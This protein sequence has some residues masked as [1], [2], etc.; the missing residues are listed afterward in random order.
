M[1]KYR[2]MGLLPLLLF[3]TMQSQNLHLSH[4]SDGFSS[5]VELSRH[6]PTNANLARNSPK[7]A[8]TS[9]PE[10]LEI[11]QNHSSETH[12]VHSRS[13][14]HSAPRTSLF[15][16]EV[17][18]RGSSTEIQTNSQNEQSSK[19]GSGGHAEVSELVFSEVKP[20]AQQLHDI[21]L[22]NR[23]LTDRETTLRN[24][25][26]VLKKNQDLAFAKYL[27]E[28]S[29]KSPKELAKL[30]AMNSSP[31]NLCAML[32]TIIIAATADKIDHKR[33][34]ELT[35]DE[36]CS[37]AVAYYDL[38]VSATVHNMIALSQVKNFEQAVQ[39]IKAQEV[40]LILPNETTFLRIHEE[41]K[42]SEIHTQEQPKKKKK[43][44]QC[45]V[46]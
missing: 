15:N 42:K 13:D 5:A 21:E 6:S 39:R 20:T 43:T 38:A 44:S 4:P 25:E 33:P 2:Y 3:L 8:L 32:P 24:K 46:S 10:S 9:I 27:Q 22:R 16:F 41:S 23:D 26:G 35:F 40:P 14:G 30:I 37:I 29:K 19:M 1:V 45:N 34:R 18:K 17:D 12:I 28:K 11:S 36:N 31:Q 7:N